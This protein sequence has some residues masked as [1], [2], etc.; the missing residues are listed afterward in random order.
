MSQ[1][2]DEMTC[3]S[4]SKPV[5][6]GVHISLLHH[7]LLAV[8]WQSWKYSIISIIM[9]VDFNVRLRLRIVMVAMHSRNAM[10][11]AKT[12]FLRLTPTSALL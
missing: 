8:L 7:I 11:V 6:C 1:L 3:S 9:A 5:S 12:E 4:Q 2:Y 10:V